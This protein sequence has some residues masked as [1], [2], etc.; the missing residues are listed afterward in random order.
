M[1]KTTAFFYGLFMDPDILRDQG[2]SPS[3]PIVAKL[4]DYSFV[5]GQRAS[6]IPKDGAECWGTIM[7]LDL[8][9]LDRL[10]SEPS[11]EMYH[12]CDVVCQDIKENQIKA[13]TYILPKDY[14]LDPPSSSDYAQKL[15]KICSKLA[16][17]APY[18]DKIKNLV[19][20]I[21]KNCKD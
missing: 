21:D 4:P 1:S 2:L 16:L 18:C 12:P 15:L 5:L 14:P 13:S 3:A 10:Y 9:E 17:P 7:Q 6:M 8:A 20:E 11:V 19:V